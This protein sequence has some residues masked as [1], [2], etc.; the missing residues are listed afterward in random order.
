MRALCLLLLVSS[1]KI[2]PKKPSEHN[3]TLESFIES[4]MTTCSSPTKGTAKQL[5]IPQISRIAKHY[6]GSRTHQEAFVLLLCIESKF[7]SH[8]KS[9]VGAIGMAQIMPQYANEFASRC[10]LTMDGSI[11]PTQ[12]ADNEVNLH[13]GACVL[14]GLIYKYKGNIALA[15]S[16]YNS[17]PASPTTKKLK[18]LQGGLNR[19]TSEYISRFFMLKQQLLAK[20]E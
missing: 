11:T 12:L 6:M 3:G 1:C 7:Q 14:S 10:S 8:L 2:E 16:A 15:L 17:G 13:L 19:E 18:K 5:L 9:S 4:V 20:V